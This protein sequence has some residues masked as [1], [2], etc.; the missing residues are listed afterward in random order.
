MHRRGERGRGHMW[1]ESGKKMGYKTDQELG[2]EESTITN[3]S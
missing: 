1:H 2:R 3:F